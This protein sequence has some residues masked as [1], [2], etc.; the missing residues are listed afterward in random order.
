MAILTNRTDVVANFVRYY[1]RQPS[2]A[3]DLATVTYLTT[4]PP[5]EVESLLAKNSP[6]T[7]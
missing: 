4:K 2:S 6:V 5:S 1:G 7:G 3:Q